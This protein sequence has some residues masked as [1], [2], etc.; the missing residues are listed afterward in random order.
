MC[1]ALN[2]AWG[3]VLNDG[4]KSFCGTFNEKNYCGF[5]G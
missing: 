1:K 5:Q 4:S 3:E 2:Y